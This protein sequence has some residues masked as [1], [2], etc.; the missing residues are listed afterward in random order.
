MNDVQTD[1]LALQEIQAD[2]QKIKYLDKQIQGVKDE[3]D[4]QE[5]YY[6]GEKLPTPPAKSNAK[7]KAMREKANASPSGTYAVLYTLCLVVAAVVALFIGLKQGALSAILAAGIAWVGGAMGPI[8]AVAGCGLGTWI[9][10]KCWS[11]A[12]TTQAIILV[13]MAIGTIIFAYLYKKASDEEG[14][15]HSAIK[16]QEK[17]EEIEFKRAMEKYEKT[18]EQIEKKNAEALKIR[19]KHFYD[20]ID[21]LKAQ[22]KAL[23]AKIAQNPVLD[24][25]DK[26]EEVVAFLISQIQRKRANSLSEALVQYDN[27]TEQERKA[28]LER[29]ERQLQ[30]DMERFAR[31]QQIRRE[32]DEQFNQA[33]HRLK[34]EKEQRRQ[35]EELER[36]RRELER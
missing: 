2:F 14:D 11:H 23:R 4:S 28:E 34:V 31:D 29:F 22:Q 27:K 5:A 26:K 25:S 7:S 24:D 10:W 1:L 12:N 35:T 18:V 21:E 9:G 3:I 30:A 16:E 32:A 17:L 8:W 19:N 13:L 15:I 33:M 6:E 36:I 20:Q